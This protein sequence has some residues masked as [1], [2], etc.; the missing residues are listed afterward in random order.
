M[1]TLLMAGV[2]ACGALGCA[3]VQVEPERFERAE[4]SIQG[5]EEVGAAEVPAARLHLQLAKDQKDKAKS[6]ATAGDDRAV[7]VLA[8][9]DADAELALALARESAM[10]TDAAKATAD[11][12]ALKTRGAP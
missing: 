3:T 4:A 6:L 8:R 7:L 2:A 11:L 10:A 12:K 1:R 9:A 5:A